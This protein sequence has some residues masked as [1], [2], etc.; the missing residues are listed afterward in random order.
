MSSRVVQRLQ[1]VKPFIRSRFLATSTPAPSRRP[2]D[3][4]GSSSSS[5]RISE[6]S[7]I[8]L[9]S[10]Q[11]QGFLYRG[12]GAQAATALWDDPYTYCNGPDQCLP[13]MSHKCWDATIP[14]E[15]QITLA[16]AAS[17]EPVSVYTTLSR[18][19]EQYPDQAALKVN[20]TGEWVTMTYAQYLE[21]CI[22]AA[23]AFIKLGLDRHYGVA[24]MGF[25]SPEWFI[26]N[27]GCIFAGGISAGMY[28]SNSAETCLHMAEDSRAQILVLEDEAAVEK[29]LSVSQQLTHV[30]AIIQWTGTPTASGVMTW[31]EFLAFGRDQSDDQLQ[32][33]L[34]QQAVNQ[35][36]AL[37]YTSGTTGPPKG[38]MCS[39]DNLTWCGNEYAKFF[40]LRPCDETVVSYLPLNHI[41]GQMTDIYVAMARASTVYFAR[42]DALKGSLIHTLREVQPTGFLTVPRLLE[43]IQEQMLTVLGKAGVVRQSAMRH[44]RAAAT[45]RY[46]ALI[47]GRKLT[48]S[49]HLHYRLFKATVLDKIKTALGLSNARHLV[50]GSAPVSD[51]LIEFFQSLDLPV[52]NAYAMSESLSNGTMC[53]IKNG[54]FKTGS[55][56]KPVPFANISIRESALSSGS[57]E[58]EGE[59][60]FK[61]RSVFMGYLNNQEKT[62]ETILDDGWMLTGDLGWTDDEDFMYMSGR[63]KE[64]IITAGGENIAPIPIEDAIK[65]EL[66]AMSNV[67]VVGDKKKF[68]SVLMTLKCER[69]LESGAA[70]DDLLPGVVMWLQ[71]YKCQATTV[72][73]VRDHIAKHPRG[74]LVRAI[75][76]GVDRYNDDHAVSSVH[77]IRRWEILPSEFT[78]VTGELSNTLKLKRSYVADFYADLIDSMYPVRY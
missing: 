63:A 16:G 21:Q 68:L 14:V 12:L 37:I 55:I 75:Q 38:V 50:S 74:A 49:E 19:A 53:S 3:I 48:M 13:A 35:C 27:I 45:N 65:R 34:R 5:S 57:N 32:L 26:A 46:Q 71:T 15:I 10:R 43:K 51:D 4:D 59:I 62:N 73:G 40:K 47:H 67:M 60:C 41:A 44:A 8:L 52:S 7:N 33:R 1:Q 29:M 56:G 20:R 66:P 64:I 2:N 72:T 69:V 18:V 42:P 23:K 25:N 30:K 61:G 11:G 39:Q 9:P 70:L 76:M 22:A 28:T 31:D 24:I 6:K 78:V 54:S 17:H 58:R 77:Q 36:C